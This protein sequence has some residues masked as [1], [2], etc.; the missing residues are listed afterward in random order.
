M[1]FIFHNHPGFALP[2][3]PEIKREPP[4]RTT[5]THSVSS[6]STILSQ[7]SEGEAEEELPPRRVHFDESVQVYVSNPLSDADIEER[8]YNR[9][10][11]RSFRREAIK[12]ASLIVEGEHRLMGRDVEPTTEILW[13]AYQ[14]FCNVQ[15]SSDIKVLLSST[16]VS[17]HCSLV[18]LDHWTI[19]QL[20]QDK[21][22]R[23][24]RILRQIQFIQRAYRH[25]EPS[26]RET[27]IRQISRTISQPSRLYAYYIA[28][29]T[30]A[31]A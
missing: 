24:S 2:Q 5:S 16:K 18:G 30:W 22:D 27:N 4:P 1:K 19:A 3:R 6:V 26:L 31:S 23:R 10:C 28:N 20:C 21:M 15:T 29:A 11:L 8:W 7:H 25:E 9:E 14:G 13:K 17:I 12:Q